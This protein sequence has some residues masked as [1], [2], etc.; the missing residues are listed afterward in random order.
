METYTSSPSCPGAS[1]AAPPVGVEAPPVGLEALAAAVAG[2]AAD[3]L[4]GLGDVLLAEQVL[5]MRQLLDQAEGAWLR[6]L[7]AADAR[8]AGG[9]ERGGTTARRPV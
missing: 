4:D 5:A 1:P 8:G 9:A 7:A 3:D 6:L 2:L